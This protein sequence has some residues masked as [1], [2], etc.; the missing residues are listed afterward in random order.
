[1]KKKPVITAEEAVTHIKDGD[2]LLVGGFMGLGSP[3]MQLKA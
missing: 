2:R 3:P 1:M